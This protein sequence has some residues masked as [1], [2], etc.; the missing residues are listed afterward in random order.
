MSLAAYISGP[1]TAWH[2]GHGGVEEIDLASL[3]NGQVNM[4]RVY[5]TRNAAIRHVVVEARKI[6]QSWID[7]AEHY[8]RMLQP[9]T[10]LNQMEI[11]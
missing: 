6:A 7:R 5:P 10:D 1:I 11:E 8:E 3:G 2:A 9:E 4:A